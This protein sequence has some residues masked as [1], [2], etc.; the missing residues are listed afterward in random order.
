MCCVYF[1]IYIL[2]NLRKV[3][4]Y[5]SF[6][7][8][9]VPLFCLLSSGTL[10]LC[11]LELLCLPVIIYFLLNNFLLL[12]LKENPQFGLPSWSSC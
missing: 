3:F 1:P 8:G 11:V 10:I 6:D 12:E 7:I 4:L 2:F 5:V 9:S